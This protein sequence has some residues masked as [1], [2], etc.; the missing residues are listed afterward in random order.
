MLKPELTRLNFVGLHPDSYIAT[1]PTSPGHGKWLR[2]QQQRSPADIGAWACR[3]MQ[4]GLRPA[5]PMTY[6]GLIEV[7]NKW[8]RN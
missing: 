5:V 3:G 4:A 1:I 8:M 2:L 6:T 7:K